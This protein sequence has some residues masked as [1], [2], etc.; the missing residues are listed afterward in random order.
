MRN[1]ESV[2]KAVILCMSLIMI[3]LLPACCAETAKRAAYESLQN[4]SD[5]DCRSNPG[6]TCPEK[7]SYDDYQRD[8]KKQ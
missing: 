4:K 2:M 6:A 3:L 5:M 8:L 1:E 7:Q